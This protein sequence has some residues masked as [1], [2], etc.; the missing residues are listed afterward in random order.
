MVASSAAGNAL[1]RTEFRF[2]YGPFSRQML[3][4]LANGP[5]FSRVSV[6]AERIEIRFG[7]SFQMSIPRSEI[8]SAVR[9]KKPF[10]AGF[11]VHGWRGRWVIN[12]SNDGIVQLTFR[13]PQQA[14]VVG[15]PVKPREIFLSLEDPDGF[16]VAISS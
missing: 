13:Q 16:L 7:W 9:S 4:L 5:S 12:G 6:N 3:S 8:A 2:S 11:G 1:A 14:R 10:G 15:F